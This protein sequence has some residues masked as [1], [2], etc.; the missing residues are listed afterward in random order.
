M[1]SLSNRIYENTQSQWPHWV[2]VGRWNGVVK[3]IEVQA[4]F[5]GDVRTRAHAEIN[6]LSGVTFIE[7][8]Y[9]PY[10]KDE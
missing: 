1:T 8:I 5:R 9:G 6:G 4:K 10:R 7:S 3:S 2:V